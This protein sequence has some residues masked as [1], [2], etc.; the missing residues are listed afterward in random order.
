MIL[1]D[2]VILYLTLVVVYVKLHWH[3]INT[4][5]T[6]RTTV[7]KIAPRT[8]EVAFHIGNTLCKL[9]VRK[10]RG[11]HKF[12]RI[13]ADEEDVSDTIQ[14][15]IECTPE[16]VTPQLVGFKTLELWDVYGNATEVLSGDLLAS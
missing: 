8:Y 16:P 10:H 12:I 14:P 6:R 3:K 9:I 2:W 15:Y 7:T 1:V 4:F 5:F 11:P 13:T